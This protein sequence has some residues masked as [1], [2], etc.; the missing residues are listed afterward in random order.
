MKL[1]LTRRQF[2]G[3]GVA[4]S[5]LALAPKGLLAQSSSAN[6]MVVRTDSPIG[7]VKPEFHSQF[8]EHLGS[9][10]YGGLWVGRN[11]PIPNVSGYRKQ[12]IEYLQAL[13][14]PVLRWP[15]GCYADDYHWRDGIGPAEARPKRVNIHWGG[16][17]EDGGFGTHEF[18]GLCHLIGAQPYIAGNVGSGSPH[19]L[20]QWIEYCNMPAGSTLAEER[21]KNGS[22]EP[23]RVRYWGIGNENWGCGGDMRPDFYGSLFRR[24]AV[25][26]QEYGG[27]KPFMIA[28]GPSGDDRNWT[29]GLMD[30]MGRRMPDGLS[31]HYYENGADAPAEYTGADCDAQLSLFAKLENA[32]IDQRTLLDGYREGSKIGL[33]LDEWGVWDKI[34][35]EDQRR[36]GRLWQQSTMRSGVAAGL[37]LN[38]F[39]RQAD[40][41][42][43]CNIAQIV[44]VLQSMLLTDGPEGTDCIRTANYYAFLLF[45]PHRGK[46]AVRVETGDSSPLAPSASA[47]IK[48]NEMVL[49]VVNP[50][51]DTD[52]EID[53]QLQG[54][55]AKTGKAQ[56]LQDS[57]W[58]AHNSFDHPNRIVPRSHPVIV[59]GSRVRMGLPRMGVA[60]IVLNLA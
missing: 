41:L 32:I 4:L 57:D 52:V 6:R 8:A 53:F 14:V 45:K 38:V 13:G 9:C 28:C 25:Y 26:V 43:M 49:S 15:G 31:M 1:D 16:Y 17:V 54:V 23:F 2:V 51:H 42:Y 12:A 11:S 19:E 20:E 60:T 36:Y 40:K 7:V 55:K 3:S 27:T 35:Q 47:S 10:V 50:K 37:G 5:I 18:I 39:N 59:E 21:I 58:N 24:F 48:D 30:S 44:N 22:A 33:V 46:T 34:P 29:R 56:I